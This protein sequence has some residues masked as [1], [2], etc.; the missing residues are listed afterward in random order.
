MDNRIIHSK[1]DLT[2]LQWSHA[3]N[4]SGTAGTFLKSQSVLSGQKVY[5][6]LSNFDSERG[7]I[8]HESVNEIIV[9]RLLMLLGIEHVE[10]QLIHADI[11]IEGKQYETYVCASEDF[12][13]R[14]ET[15][16]ALDNYYAVNRLD[17]ESRYEFCKRCGW[18]SYIDTMLVVDY[19][20]LNRDRHGANI[21]VLRNARKHTMRIAPLFDHG[22]SLLCFCNS[23]QAVKNYDVM[24]DIA[25]NNFIGSKSSEE[26]LGLIQSGPPIAKGKLREESRNTILAGLEPILSQELLDKIWDMIWSRWCHYE[27]FFYHR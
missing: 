24:A 10:Y 11:Q 25:C 7:I 4:S 8:G 20:I 23:E 6:K 9:D 14:G 26:N 16:T 13:Q 5:Y 3:R 27:D 12:K 19:L 17:G 1:Q 18:Q 2:F 22:V 15:K 21:E